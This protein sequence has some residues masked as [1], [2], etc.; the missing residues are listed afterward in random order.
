MSAIF[1]RNCSA[2]RNYECRNII[3]YIIGFFGWFSIKS[4]FE[5]FQMISVQIEGGKEL[6]AKLLQL[7]KNVGKKI[8]R[9][10]VRDAQKSLI[11][12][13]QSRKTG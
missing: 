11:P 6:E 7:E 8:V 3:F 5:H 9:T 4:N 2:R 1:I 10:G 12:A 13:M